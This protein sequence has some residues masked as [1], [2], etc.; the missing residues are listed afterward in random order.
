MNRNDIARLVGFVPG[1]RFS[2]VDRWG[3]TSR[4]KP[5]KGVLHN[6]MATSYGPGKLSIM[7]KIWLKL[8]ATGS[9]GLRKKS[10]RI[11]EERM[12]RMKRN[13]YC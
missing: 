3:K 4:G 10:S 1:M 12:R 13:Q 6:R 2:I 11:A 9:H 8:H 7:E 5:I